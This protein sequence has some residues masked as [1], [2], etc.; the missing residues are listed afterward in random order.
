MKGKYILRYSVSCNVCNFILLQKI[1]VKEKREHGRKQQIL[2]HNISF[3]LMP[4]TVVSDFIFNT[5]PPKHDRTAVLCTRNL[6][7]KGV[8]A[9]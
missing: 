7:V 2:K 1:R 9:V 5:K 3:S 4:S 6:Q 8:V